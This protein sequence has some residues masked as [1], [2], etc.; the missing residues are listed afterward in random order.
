MNIK[1]QIKNN[2]KSLN[3][4]INNNKFFLINFNNGKNSRE[5]L[6]LNSRKYT[7]MRKNTKKKSL[8]NK[9]NE[10][11]PKENY[12][13]II[14]DENVNEYFE[15]SFD[16]LDYDDVIEEDKRT[17]CIYFIEKIKENQIIINSFIIYEPI[18]PK[19][20]KIAAFIL[21]LDLY[22]LINGI[23]FSESYIS[24]IFNSTE[25][26]TLFSF[27]PRSINRF[28]YSIIVGNI[29]RYL[30][31]FFFVEE[32]KV[33]KILL[34]KREKFIDLK[35]EIE[36]LIKS[37]F[38]KI[39]IFTVINYIIMIFSWYYISCLNS[40]Y[41]NIVKEW[42]IS[43]IFII[44]I[45]QILPFIYAFLETSIR[46]FSIKCHSEKLFKLSLLFS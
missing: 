26:E 18:R 6:I 12:N 10:M 13:L 36:E 37:S 14:N 27:I 42:I 22:L 29:I 45:N 16:V 2:K 44:L 8:S 17:Y 25:K 28:A 40:V 24:E 39:K 23:F 31:E 41:P 21:T 11:K 1:S 35:I 7:K 33:K 30:I 4:K 15:S 3:L 5:N 19:S 46:Y 34:K 43:S 32:I 9:K 20:L 38:K